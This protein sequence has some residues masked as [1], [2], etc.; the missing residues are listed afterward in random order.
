MNDTLTR[1]VYMRLTVINSEQRVN[2]LV[3]ICNSVH[4]TNLSES[5]AGLVQSASRIIHPSNS[6]Y[7]LKFVSAFAK[8]DFKFAKD[9]FDRLPDIVLF[10]Y[11]ACSESERSTIRMY[12]SGWKMRAS[13]WPEI[14][15][16]CESSILLLK[17]LSSLRG[18]ETYVNPPSKMLELLSAI[19]RDGD[20]SQPET[21]QSV[22]M[23]ASERLDIL[24]SSI[25]Q[26]RSIVG[27]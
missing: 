10:C 24:V 26:I 8:R 2:E 11:Q 23:F 25:N 5:V 12:V 27:K 19:V 22:S 20:K 6:L 4:S 15:H 14:A 1:E 7:L 17:S 3:D 18:V 16:K 13:P 21:L 9:I